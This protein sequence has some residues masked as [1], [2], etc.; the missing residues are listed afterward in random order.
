MGL[1]GAALLAVIMIVATVMIHYEVLRL[2]SLL[3]PRLTMPVRSRVLVV[4]GG[5][6]IAHFSAVCLYALGYAAA[7]WD[8]SLGGIGGDFDATVLDYF[9]FSIAAYTTLGIGDVYPIGAL[10]LL[11]G[12]EAI[13]G[14]VLIGWSASFTYLS[15]E[16]FW[17]EHRRS[18]HRE[19]A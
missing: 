3:I 2:I 6:L 1:A 10:R 12:V 7:T 13:N 9:Y 5:L 16:K 18:H 19:R 8:T 4:I 15:M 11:V 17:D 14:F